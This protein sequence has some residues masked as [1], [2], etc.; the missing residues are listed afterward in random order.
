MDTKQ[1]KLEARILNKISKMTRHSHTIL[2]ERGNSA[3]YLALAIAKRINPRPH[4]LIP[5]QGGWISFKN[6]P[7][8]FNF[9]IR[10]L[11]TDYGLIKTRGLRSKTKTASAILV[12]SF[13]GYFAEQPLKSISKV[14]KETGCLL[15]EDASGAIG[16]RKLCNGKY[17]D[18][19]VGSFEKSGPISIGYGGFI[20]LSNLKYLE[21]ISDQLSIFKTHGLLYKE[22]RGSLNSKRLKKMLAKAEK[23]KKDLKKFNIIHAD[24]RGLNVV[25]RFDPEVIKYCHERDYHYTLCPNYTRINEKAICIE[26]KR[27]GI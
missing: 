19:V 12:T 27:Q 1:A 16:D 13:A 22:L 3:I 20:S 18:I 10:E 9:S 5:D 24:K 7:K 8:H 11:Q 26:L 17:A 25:T 6:Y 4:V 2:T 23:V 14:C 15:I 21:A